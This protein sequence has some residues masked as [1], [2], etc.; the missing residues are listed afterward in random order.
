MGIIRYSYKFGSSMTIQIGI[1]G[2]SG[3]A[4]A[5]LIRLLLQHPECT[6]KT[7][8]AESTAG[9]QIEELYSNI[10][11]ST[12]PKLSKL[13][14]I[15]DELASCTVVFSCLPHGKSMHIL[16]LLVNQIIIDLGA[17][18][19]LESGGDFHR[20]YGEPHAEPSVLEDW[21]YG[22]PEL[23]RERIQGATRI[24][25]PGCYPTAVSIALAPLLKE[26]LIEE[27]IVVSAVSGTTG[28]GRAPNPQLHF[29][30]VHE[31][32]FAYK[33][34]RHQHTG[35]MQMALGS[36]A[37]CDP[38]VSFT[39]HVGPMSRGINATCSA[40]LKD[41]STTSQTLLN[42][43]QDYYQN[44]VFVDV[45]DSPVGTKA[46][47][48]SNRVIV[49]AAV[50]EHASRATIVSVIDNLTKGAAGQAVQNM[51]IACHFDESLALP[52]IGLYP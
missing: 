28:A 31:N 51:N 23:F 9:L 16:P 10:N 33:L 2:A 50:D 26:Q 37:N 7:L 21:V 20:W 11:Q 48:G 3:Y 36:F 19:R 27:D 35:E 43:L 12:L 25:N 24:A 30:H 15:R 40:R 5:E 34:G 32:L 44:E 49:S 14:D 38:I 41:D 1:L 17:D 6:I 8:S 39:A 22:L 52:T 47:R 29:S 18:F 42:C 46:V 4:G 13:D 45:V